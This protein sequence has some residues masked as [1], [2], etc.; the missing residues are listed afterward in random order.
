MKTEL[1]RL[2]STRLPTLAPGTWGTAI[3]ELVHVERWDFNDQAFYPRD[4]TMILNPGDAIRTTCTYD[5]PG[6]ATVRF[7]ERTEDEMCFN[8]VM[9]YP[10]EALGEQR[11]CGVI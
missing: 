7:G 9:L 10:I 3:E 8:F 5:N 11:V 1:P 2:L 4:P 6:D